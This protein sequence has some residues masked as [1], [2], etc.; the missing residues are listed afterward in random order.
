VPSLKEFM[1]QTFI[2]T[3]ESGTLSD[4]SKKYYRSGWKLLS[5]ASLED[6]TRLEDLCLDHIT[7]TLADALEIPH[8]GS[9][10][11]MALPPAGWLNCKTSRFG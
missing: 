4:K 9:N 8:S 11:N 2:P 3:I 6:E 5:V 10:Q 7:T 1:T